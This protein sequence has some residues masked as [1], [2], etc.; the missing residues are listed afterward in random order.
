[1]PQLNPEFFASQ[2]FWL[3][4][5]FALIYV[6][7]AKYFLPRVGSVVELRS[8]QINEDIASSERIIEDYKA[9]ELSASKI[10]EKAKHE[11]FAIVDKATKKAEA[12]I[13]DKTSIIERDINKT[14]AKKEEGLARMKTQM[15]SDIEKLAIDVGQQ[16]T[17]QL[18]DKLE[19]E[20]SKDVHRS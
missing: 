6:L 11:S 7:I 20:S 16:V 19:F 14:T 18:M 9:V 5:V 3:L 10:L 13:L 17:T 1:M 15:H 4:I 8:S 2:I 12:Q